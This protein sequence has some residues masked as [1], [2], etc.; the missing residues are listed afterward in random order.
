MFRKKSLYHTLQ[1][2]HLKP[3]LH[4]YSC[5]VLDVLTNFLAI[6]CAVNLLLDPIV[7]R[8][9]EVSS[10]MVEETSVEFPFVAAGTHNKQCNIC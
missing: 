2:C 6:P 9:E 4:F 8:P 3:L 10:N 1:N 5:L 7:W